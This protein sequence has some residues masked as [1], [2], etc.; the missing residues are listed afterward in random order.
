[1]GI[2]I[3]QVLIVLLIVV[4]LFGTKKL[5]SVGGDLGEAFKGFKK[6]IQDD[7]VETKSLEQNDSIIEE[8]LSQDY[9]EKA[10]SNK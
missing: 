5:R 8:T 9:A 7:P 2:S 1:M 10:S 4:L 3:W 6:G